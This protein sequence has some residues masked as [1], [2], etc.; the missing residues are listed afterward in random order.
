MNILKK[1][2]FQNS[3]CIQQVTSAV[4]DCKVSDIK[5]EIWVE[6]TSSPEAPALEN[7][8]SFT[9]RYCQYLSLNFAVGNFKEY[10]RR[11][12]IIKKAE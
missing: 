12:K 4:T 2:V 9:D 3:L 8:C 6:W 1:N 5:E 10:N 11:E 7:S